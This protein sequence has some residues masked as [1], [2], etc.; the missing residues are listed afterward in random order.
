MLPVHATGRGAMEATLCNSFSPSDE[1]AV[2]CNGRFGEM[3][4]RIASPT[5]CA[6][7]ASR[8]SGTP[9]SI[10]RGRAD[11]DANPRIRGVALAHS[12]TSTG[13][14]NDVQAIARVARARN[15]LV[16]VDGVSSIGGMPFAFDDWGVDAAITASQKCLMSSPGLSFA[17]VS[18][19]GRAAIAAARLPHSYWDFADIKRDVTKPKPE[20]PG[21][22]PVHLV[23]QVAE[24]LRMIHAEGL[25]AVYAR[26]DKMAGMVRAGAAAL[27]LALAVSGAQRRSATVHW[28]HAA[29]R[30]PAHQVRHGL[31]ARG[32]LTA[33][34]VEHY[35]ER[36]FGYGH[37]GDIRP[38][39][40]RRTLDALGAVLQ[41]SRADSTFAA[42][43]GS[44]D[45]TLQPRI[46]AGLA[47][48]LSP[49]G[50]RGTSTRSPRS[51]PASNRSGRSSSD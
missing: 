2:C 48:A 4:G 42:R 28:H 22:P 6:C 47:Q 23:L 41:D 1:I 49:E 45:V 13:V 30:A 26:H 29:A 43:A 39:D 24:A 16:L 38:A 10:R 31:K 46:I 40:V 27:G 9:R 15:V 36:R 21:T 12:D 17:V 33:A 7:D 5:A 3:W 35:R 8:P 14:A 34:G 20:T 32:I 25:D 11:A 50:W 51:S 37:M 44:R 18:E 19:R